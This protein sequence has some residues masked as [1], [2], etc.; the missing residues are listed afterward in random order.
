MRFWFCFHLVLIWFMTANKFLHGNFLFTLFFLDKLI[1]WSEKNNDLFRN[2]PW[3]C[4]QFKSIK[5]M[6]SYISEICTYSHHIRLKNIKTKSNHFLKELTECLTCNRGNR[7]ILTNYPLKKLQ[8]CPG[9]NTFF[10]K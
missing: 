1:C 6:N 3:I 9:L 5:N 4:A 8:K 2:I 7:W 10:W